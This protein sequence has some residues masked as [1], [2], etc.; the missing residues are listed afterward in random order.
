MSPPF[1]LTSSAIESING[2]F[3]RHPAIRSAVIYGSRAK[4]NFKPGSDIDLCLFAEPGAALSYREVA[5]VLD[6]IDD[7]LLPW[8]VDLSAFE[9][10]ANAELR[11]HIER[12]GLEFYQRENMT[13]DTSG[14]ALA[15]K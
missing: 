5:L 11:A 13:S 10:L 6:E 1:G 2:V 8:T 12:V 7:L 14:Q 15:L 9:Q 4:G 3:A